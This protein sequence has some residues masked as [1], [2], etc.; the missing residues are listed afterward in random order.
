MPKTAIVTGSTGFI[1]SNLC[2]ALLEAGYRVRAFHRPN[3]TLALIR[4]LDVDHALGDITQPGTIT[5]AMKGVDVVFHAA[6]NVDYWRGTDGM[7]LVT[8][9][10]TRNCS[11]LLLGAGIQR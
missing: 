8:V 9:G 2:R 10:G 4:D 7:Y 11:G 1:G 5:A 3:S 6:S